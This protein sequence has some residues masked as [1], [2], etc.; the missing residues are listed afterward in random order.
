[1]T[2][3][4]GPAL[5][6]A[7]ESVD[8][9]SI[10]SLT[11][12]STDTLSITG[13]SLTIASTSTLGGP[14]TMIGGYLEATGTAVNVT[15]SGATTVSDASLYAGA[16]ATLGLPTLTSSISNGTFQ[17]NG[18]RERAGCVGPDHADPRRRLDRQCP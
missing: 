12:G 17:A 15:V 1:M 5:T 11:T 2:I 4:T 3:N 10:G 6:V 16:G 8:N 13:G 9:E 14:L 7:I 18:Y